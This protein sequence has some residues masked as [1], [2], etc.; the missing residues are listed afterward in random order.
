VSAHAAREPRA[1]MERLGAA[2]PHYPRPAGQPG[3]ACL[4][5]P[6]WC[7]SRDY[8]TCCRQRWSTW[9]GRAQD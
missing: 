6:S 8:S 5:T 1:V 2:A 3:P 9:G 4:T 7:T